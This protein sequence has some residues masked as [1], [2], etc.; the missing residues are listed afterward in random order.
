M[1]ETLKQS[2]LPYL[3]RG[4]GAENRVFPFM[5]WDG[6]EFGEWG[7]EVFSPSLHLCV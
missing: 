1:S 3:S 7:L 6:C 4:G 2:L 5:A